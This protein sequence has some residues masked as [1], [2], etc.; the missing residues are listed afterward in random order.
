VFK[1]FRG[2]IGAIAVAGLLALPLSA[3]GL[4]FEDRVDCQT[5][6]EEVAWRHRIWPAGNPGPKPALAAVM[7]RAAIVRKVED[8]LAQSALLA[9][10][11]HTT[12]APAELQ[13]ELDRMTRESRSPA[14]LAELFAALGNDPA[15]AAE[16]LARPALTERRLLSFEGLASPAAPSDELPR[17]AGETGCVNDTWQATTTA[18]APVGREKHTAVW[19]GSEMIVWGGQNSSVPG[20]TLASGGRYD[21]ATDTWSPV[22]TSGAVA[23]S[24]HTAVW[25]GT[26]MLVWGGDNQQVGL[27]VTGGLY[28]PAAN[29][30][31]A[32]STTGAPAP[33]SGHTAVWAQNRMIVW[34]GA[35]AGGLQASGGRY[36][37]ATNTWAATTTTGA[38]AGRY[39][40][41]AVSTGSKMIVW[42]GCSAA[43]CSPDTFLNS[44]GVYD[45]V[46]NSWSA[47]STA[48]A[49]EPRVY[50]TAVWTGNRMIVWGG[51][52]AQVQ[53]S[54]SLSSGGVYNPT[55]DTWVATPLTGAP[56]GRVQHAAVWTGKEMVV[57]G[58]L[59]SDSG[60]YLNNGGRYD[61]E[62]GS[63]SAV[64]TA[65]GL[66]GRS[67]YSA[68]WTG[69]EVIVWGGSGF[70]IFNDGG[71]YCAGTPQ[72]VALGDS[73][74]SG[75]GAYSYLKGTAEPGENTCHRASTAYSQV[76]RDVPRVATSFFA[77]SGDETINML[78]DPAGTPRCFPQNNPDDCAPYSPPD[79]IP[80]LDQPEI[81]SADLITVTIGGNDARFSDVLGWCYDETSCQDYTPSGFGGRKLRDHMPDLIEEVGTR[82]QGVL[83]AIKM[84]NPSADLRVLGYPALFPAAAGAQ[85]CGT[86]TDPACFGAWE[87]TEQSWLN[88]LVPLLNDAL[89]QAALNVHARFVPVAG[90]DAFAGHEICGPKGSW[91]VPPP[92]WCLPALFAKLSGDTFS[93]LFHPTPEGHLGG[94]RRDLEANFARF[95]AGGLARQAPLSQEELA[96]MVRQAETA[97]AGLPTLGKL[98]VKVIGS[99]CTGADVAIPGGM[100]SIA[101]D[102]FAPGSTVTLTL[103]TPAS[104][105]LATFAAD[106][107]GRLRTTASIP[108]GVQA[109]GL[110]RLE[111][112]GTGA[113]LL[114]QLLV[115]H[116]AI[117]P[118]LGVDQDHDGVADAC[119]NCS[120]ANAAQTDADADGL[121][122]P[123]DTCPDDPLNDVDGDGLCA[124]VDPCPADPANDADG[125][126]V[127]A[128]R[129]VC[130]AVADPSQSDADQDGFGDACDAC[131]DQP[132]TQCALD[133][134][135]VLPC[136]VLDTRTTDEPLLATSPSPR[137]VRIAGLCGI[138]ATARAVFGNLTAI[139]ATGTGNIQTWPTDLQATGTSSLNF[140]AG[141]TRANN[142]IVPLAQDGFGDIAV[143]AV[144]QGGGS[145]HLVLD[146][147]GYFE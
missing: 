140:A 38:P 50:Q 127:C 102:G 124:E 83:A 93:E 81:A 21:P 2:G 51:G 104:Q 130:P 64:S 96:A 18:G 8:A 39:F 78:P 84:K 105:V 55:N 143:K 115:T 17:L 56:Q 101:G 71:R 3:A 111:A 52:A 40:H 106:G 132:G 75:E 16:C 24:S 54:H 32:M 9:R 114:P 146:V 98:R 113:N 13:A 23:R 147:S 5:A 62:T 136:R 122:V 47:T 74:S 145:V 53:P 33:R 45:P 87:P 19:T 137:I 141:L 14:V 128:E 85:A 59:F 58:G 90:D 68:V 36:D 89:R 49:P 60:T 15:R 126:G 25:T 134:H 133:Y 138:P 37:P 67:F 86:L 120:A 66:V 92:Q 76:A 43:Q 61:P 139:G 26:R 28:D 1:P 80:Q 7:P 121:G 73:F 31:S 70:G 88:E 20:I 131:P 91:F 95:P 42:G 30:W 100:L 99:P 97:G 112:A 117:G 79:H 63:W 27:V 57:W 11:Y 144:V 129:D 107:A 118:A 10:R 72:W 116:I 77:C 46:S 22:S 103:H 108:L 4:S 12:L 94:Y 109:Q 41:A 82:V 135:T 119:D 110:A 65:S 123:C 29:S 48:G 35:G 6:I 142:A 44:G 34:G 125:D 69:A